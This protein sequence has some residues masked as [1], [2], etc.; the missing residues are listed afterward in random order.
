VVLP[1]KDRLSTLGETVASVFDQDMEEWELLLVTASAAEAAVLRKRHAPEARVRVLVQKGRGI[2]NARNTGMQTAR[3]LYIAHMDDD[4]VWHPSHLGELAE[5]LD[6]NPS[7]GLV[8]GDVRK[9]RGRYLRGRYVEKENLGAPWCQPFD[10]ERFR[11]GNWIPASAAM[12]RA[13]LCRDLGGFDESFHYA[14]D[15]EYWLRIASRHDVAHRCT[16]KDLG[17]ATVEY[18][19]H[20]NNATLRDLNLWGQDFERIAR[21]YGQAAQTPSEVST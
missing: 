9:S 12:Q 18:R 15:W 14:D 7:V 13:N 6:Y 19:I 2:A 21:R 17:F 3:G 11:Q 16:L 8:Y 4:E 1:T 20:G 10:M 5:L